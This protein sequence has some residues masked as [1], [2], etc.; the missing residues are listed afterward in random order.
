MLYHLSYWGQRFYIPCLGYW[1]WWYIQVK[2]TVSLK[3]MNRILPLSNRYQNHDAKG[4]FFE[5]TSNAENV[6]MWWRLHATS[7]SYFQ[8]GVV[9]KWF[10]SCQQVLGTLSDVEAIT[11]R[12][13]NMS[14]DRRLNHHLVIS[15]DCWSAHAYNS[16]YNV[17]GSLDTLS[18]TLSILL[19]PTQCTHG[20]HRKP[21][22]RLES[23]IAPYI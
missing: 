20:T 6:S 15:R 13:F 17:S 5:K 12:W 11:C 2:F 19:V 9:M 16:Y 8:Y 1:L 21:P 3:N 14:R 4:T 7:T 22:G 18:T 23:Q 10:L